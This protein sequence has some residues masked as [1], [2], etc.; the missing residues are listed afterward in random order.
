MD[1]KKKVY[2]GC[3]GGIWYPKTADRMSEAITPVD[4]ITNNG[5]TALHVA[6]GSTSMVRSV[7]MPISAGMTASVP[8]VSKNG[9]SPLLDL[10]IVRW[11]H[12][13]CESSPIQSLLL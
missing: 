12:R 5:N 9:V 10:I 1:D 7:G 3:L 11:D 13:T 2:N 4:K 8:Y 6:V